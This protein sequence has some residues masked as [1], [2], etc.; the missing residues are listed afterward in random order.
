VLR[1]ALPGGGSN[2]AVPIYLLLTGG[3]TLLFMSVFTV[4]L[5][6]HVQTVGLSPLQL[7]LVGT[8]LEAVIVLFEIPTGVVADLVS[9]R[10][11]ILIGLVFIGLGF[12]VEGA[13]PVF[14]AILAAQVLW[15][16]GY[17]FTSGATEAWITD[18][19]GEE[20]VGP[21]LLRGTQAGLVGTVIGILLATAL[22][23][24]SIRL[25]IVLGGVGFI[26]L[27]LILLRTMPE[28]NFHPTPRED[29]STAR[30]MVETF[31]AGLAVARSRPVVRVLLVTSLLLGLASEAF[32]RLWAKHL[33]DNVGFP[34][35][36]GDNDLVVWFGVIA[37][38]GTTL[39]L[40]ATEVFRHLRPESLGPGTPTRMLALLAGGRVLSTVVFALAGSL[41]L[42]LAMFWT[43]DLLSSLFHPV[44]QAWMNRNIDPATRATVL[45]FQEQ[46]ASAGEIAGGPPLGW[47]G[48]RF[49]VQAAI[50]ATGL[51]YAPVI[52]VFLRASHLRDHITR[53]S[54]SIEG[55]TTGDTSVG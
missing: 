41:P 54:P 23:L 8:T 32:D 42:A 1:L 33:I 7:V 45:S 15:G 40:I 46:V 51:V 30:H 24:V 52:A 34:G 13:F 35:I 39:S 3:S 31:R 10:R 21:V 43:R 28:T 5:L 2:P 50:V 12:I 48:S 18:E 55:S 47:V 14:T 19:V 22:G 6:Y 44:N 9:R 38:V 17:T 20:H 29:R 25:P 49:G 4:N 27:A 36:P 16:I 37:L 26:A 11:S 53:A